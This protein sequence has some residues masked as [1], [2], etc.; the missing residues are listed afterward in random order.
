MSPPAL[1]AVVT[2]ATALFFSA[3]AAA[4][5]P[6]AA[7]PVER[8]LL[9]SSVE[10]PVAA[11]ADPKVKQVLAKLRSDVRATGRLRIIAGVRAAFAPEALLPPAAAQAQR[12]DIA[13]AQQRIRSRLPRQSAGDV[14]RFEVIPFIALQVDAD[15]LE[16][17]AAMAEITD[18]QEDRPARWLLPQSVP[19]IHANDAWAAGYTGTGWAVA[20]LDTGVDKSH[21][22]LGGRVISEACYS[23]TSSAYNTTSVCPGGVSAS[24][25][26][27]SGVNCPSSLPGCDHGTHVA[28][29]A[30][31][32]GTTFSGVAKAA[33][34]ISINIASRMDS[35]SDC[36][37]ISPCL[38]TY[39]SDQIRGL[40]RVYE[41]RNGYNIAAV[42][43]SLGGGR[44]D[45]RAACDAANASHKAI[46]DTL[47]SAGIATIAGTGND[48]Y[49]DSMAAPACLS[50]VVSVGAVFDVPGYANNGFGWNGGTSTADAVSYFS[51]AAAFL[52]LLAPGIMINSSIPG[53][54]FANYWGTSMAVPHVT[55]CWAILKQARPAATVDQVE[56]AIKATG[57]PVQDWR[58]GRITPRID[59]DAALDGVMFSNPNLLANPGFES[60]VTG[61]TQAST[62]KG[63]IITSDTRFPPH[64]G[65]WYAWFGGFAGGTDALHQDLTVPGA[66]R[67]TYVQFWYR[68]STNEESTIEVNDT[69]D[70]DIDNAFTGAQLAHL[71]TLSNVDATSGWVQSPQYDVSSF[72]GQTIRLHFSA[73][74][75]GTD[76]TNFLVDDVALV[77]VE[78][79]N[80]QGLWWNAPAGTESGWGINFAHQGDIIFATWF[81]YD[82]AG[83]PWWLIAQLDKSAEGTYSGAVYTVAGPPFNTVPFPPGGNPGGAVETPVGTMTASFADATH[84]TI[85]YTV[86]GTTQTKAIV[87][88]EFGP[89]VT[90]TWGAQPNLALATN[91][92]DLWWNAPAGSESGWGI[93]FTHQGDIVFATWFT[94]DAARKP[95]WL[96]ALLN[97][98]TAGVYAGP[99]STVT[100][101]PF[102]AV[103]FPPGGSPG[104]AVETEVGSAS[105]TFANGNAATFTYR[106]NG[107]AQTKTITRQVFIAPGT[108]CQ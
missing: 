100:G 17:L 107:T 23:T 106:V 73:R 9:G 68:I 66:A 12:D 11:S 58:N 52:D 4:A 92:T 78:R 71:A 32:Q 88:Q 42:N 99:V 30:V 101:P 54:G 36:G 83:K 79:I 16:A 87:P 37:G 26:V 103:P 76:V 70:V 28:G 47:R 48:G 97:K 84:G 65:S 108:V 75:D 14:T 96:I 40:E 93:N 5:E 19:L 86:N 35:V 51:N 98:S 80:Y 77:A 50:S 102:N 38:M 3:S 90:C 89:Q 64:A 59:C 34:L 18:I 7:K 69:L 20:L 105:V 81:T 21:P 6:T 67:R 29:I 61:W 85:S 41:L 72:K 91:Y 95:W 53:G 1:H 60:G 45:T 8:R 31:G 27:G 22:F 82:T 46:I 15:E 56:Q 43:M 33:G 39:S 63:T 57:K 55:G 104:G 10:Q 2:L 44:Y 74:N 62:G 13:A 49:V 24:T 94:Y 25:A